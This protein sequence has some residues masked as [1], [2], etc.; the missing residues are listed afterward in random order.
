MRRLALSLFSLAFSYPALAQVSISESRLLE[1]L[2]PSRTLALMKRL[3]EDVVENRS[4]AGA[5]TAVSG[6]RDEKLL[7]DFIEK[8]MAGLGFDVRRE[9]FPVRAYDSGEVTLV[10]SG[11]RIPAVTLHTSP[12]TWGTVDGVAYR[13]GSV[14]E[15]RKL[16]ATLVDAGDG[17]AADYDRASDVRGKAVL[18]R[19]TLW[20]S[21]AIVEAA[22]RGAV[23]I[24]FHGYGENSLDDALKQDSVWYRDQIPAF[25][26]RK[27]DAE[28]LKLPIEIEIEARVD[29]SYGVSENVLGA[30]RGSVH[31]DEWI[32]VS[33][34]Y[35]RW[36][37]G[38]QDDSIGV[39]SMLEL[40]RVL[41]SGH[42][43][44]RSLLLV[45]FGSEEAGAL[46]T[47]FDWLAGSYA[48]IKAH[49][50]I[51]NRLAY[52]FNLDLAGWPGEKGE[53][54]ATVDQLA[55]QKKLLDD[56]DLSSRV[57]VR[58]GLA[59]LVDAWN[60]GSVG[61]GAVSYLSW[62]GTSGGYDAFYHT[63]LDVA[64]PDHFTNLPTDLR[65]GLLGILRADDALVLPIQFSAL[66]SWVESELQGDSPVSFA[67][68]LAAARALGAEAKRIEGALAGV[69]DPAMAAP[70][71]AWLMKTRKELVPW[72][73]ATSYGG[74]SLKSAP[75]ARDLS[76]LKRARAAAERGDAAG[77]AEALERVATLSWGRRLSKEAY[78]TERL[79]SYEPSGWVWEYGQQPRPVDVDLY[80]VYR[81]V[82]SKDAAAR[83]AKL[84]AQAETHLREALFIVTGKLEES[85]RA[86]GM[87][88]V[89]RGT[90]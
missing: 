5:G 27:G 58:P 57:S 68:P 11:A 6:S 48:F 15:G 81:E 37:E 64:R 46:D 51:T 45:A 8:E 62:G 4:G 78:L 61:G 28:K 70:I 22:H 47:R 17:L 73:L 16:R 9:S 83:I 12:G 32:L 40:G 76:A 1:S 60:L 34:H 69:D 67:K 65:L 41:S 84:E 33:A 82:T 55:F 54:Y 20:P 52:G 43:P 85:T 86:L 72:L 66:A 59:A 63:Q 80:D 3:S 75:Y 42:R 29:V 10:A 44:R 30:L 31:P 21:Y 19:R 18:V 87:T 74:W 38:A 79:L 7:A 13:R 49:P 53:V 77:A 26:I 24:F 2:D 56:L 88:P 23:A 39:A 14:E 90:R 71:N 89:P 25:S 50:E 36:F 35:D